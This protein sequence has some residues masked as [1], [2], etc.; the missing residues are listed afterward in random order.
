MSTGVNTPDEPKLQAIL[1]GCKPP[2]KQP[3][4]LRKKGFQ[5]RPRRPLNLSILQTAKKPKGVVS[6]QYSGLHAANRQGLVSSIIWLRNTP[7]GRKPA[8]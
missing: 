3:K 2:L 1:R 4:Y 8:R 6:W 7:G 5:T